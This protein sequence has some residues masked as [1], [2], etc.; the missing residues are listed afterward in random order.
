MSRAANSN[1]PSVPLRWSPE[2]AAPELG[3]SHVTIRAALARGSERPGED[4][5]YSTGQLVAAIYGSMFA[6]KLKTQ[7]AI[8]KRIELKNRIARGTLVDRAALTS[9]FSQVASAMT[10]RI[11][12]S[13]LTRDEQA[14]L[15]RELA[16]VPISID[17][18]AAEQSRLPRGHQHDGDGDDDDPD[19]DDVPGIG[20]V[21]KRP[22][23]RKPGFRAEKAKTS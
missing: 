21:P 7:V 16:S 13:S 1:I 6:E 12:A 18:I 19:E 23:R 11:A 8:R 5:L 20:K 3:V 2:A 22:F 14:D 9:M 10:S 4:G 17:G 15:L